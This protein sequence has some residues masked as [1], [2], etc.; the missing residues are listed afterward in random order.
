VR[1]TRL[2]LI[3]TLLIMLVSLSAA[4]AVT[5]LVPSLSAASLNMLFRFRGQRPPP[6][7]VVIVA[8]DDASIQRVGNWPW[9][10]S[11]MASVLDR[12]TEARPR[13]IGLDIIYAEASNGTDDN[14]L[15]EAIARNGRVVLPAQLMEADAGQPDTGGASTWLLPLPEIKRA[16]QAV[17]HAHADPDVDGVLRTVQLSK[18]NER[19][20][21]LWAFGLETLRVAEGIQPEGIQELK[22][23]L[24]LG[25]YEI[26]I[27]DEAEKSSLPG[28]TIIRPN[29]LLINYLGPPGTFHYYSI[30]D[31]L[32]GQVP[33]SAFNNKIVLIGAVAQTMGDTRITPFI[34]YAGSNRQGG[35]G[36]PGVEVHANVIETIRRGA[37]LNPRP[38]WPGVIVTLL[39]IL[40]ASAIVRVFDGWKAILLLC[41][42]L[43]LIIIGSLYAFNRLYIIPPVVSM[44]TGFF[45]VVPLLLL[46]TSI[47]ASRDLDKK[48]DR[49]A[50]IQK[51]F[52]SHRAPPDAF[53]ASLSFIASILK[54][55][56]VALFQ[57]AAPGQ[58][59]ELKAHFGREPVDGLMAAN[60]AANNSEG[61]S[62]SLR[63]P[64]EDE[65]GIVG[66]L[67]I[68]RA[69]GEPFS[70]SERQLAQ[71]FAEGLSAEL[72]SDLQRSG[73]L[74]RSLS[75]PR[76]ITWKLRAVDE[77]TAHLVARV[78]FMNRVF[79][80]M[81]DGLLVADITGHVIF[82]NPAAHRFWNNQG[83]A[84]LT[85]Q[86]LTELFTERGI[87]ALDTLRETMRAVMNGQSVTRDVE[88]AAG[89]GRY[90]TLQFSAVVAAHQTIERQ[91]AASDFKFSNRAAAKVRGLIVIII[92]VTKR[93][94]LD[95]VKAETLQLVSHEL[96][97]PL[98]SIRGL[99][100]TL[101]KYPV[102]EE[103][104]PEIL[105]T[106]YS[107]SVRLSELINRYLDVTRI[108][109][110]AQVLTRRS[111]S[112]NPLISDCVRAGG[113]HAATK[114]IQI[115]LDLEEPSPALFCDPQLLAQAVNNLL[116]NAIKYSPEGSCVRISSAI[117]GGARLRIKVRDDGYGIPQEFQARI[118]E[119][120]FRLERDVKSETIGTGLGLALVKEIVERH[121]GQMTLE[122]EPGRGSTF[123]IH[124][125]LQKS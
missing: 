84:E 123:T 62:N 113:S 101:L 28:V 55:E 69:A 37:S 40:A 8:I 24:R 29:E 81:T 51:R 59:L 30:G 45:M 76:N 121:N 47:T 125:P 63:V 108:E 119:K 98:T 10:R 15:S 116:I 117:D 27:Y 65:A 120:F 91:Q 85:G 11:V 100:E 32:D 86:S 109:S 77:I 103:T 58:S 70:E 36:M 41:S 75:L 92:D 67:V 13:A 73:L 99:S 68:K 6:E 52:M 110:G 74:E 31:V 71:E 111:V 105:A 17:G 19:G 7:D 46:E 87:I 44:T 16:A 53:H 83:A 1:R 114:R 14:R 102:P 33:A 49:L 118:F 90:Y 21:R 78:S 22:G 2:Q 88:A 39:V 26:A 4:I 23:G 12:I 122:S 124:L 64:L 18:A 56:A 106:I 107:E 42:L 97:A 50:R 9:P 112:L 66:M 72:I 60:D 79:T 115:K 34:S 89:E 93:R 57:K 95:R 96:R 20:E 25:R 54:A 61:S 48:L 104:K 80:S 38:D 35:A 82:A 94:E 5:W 3:P 43:G